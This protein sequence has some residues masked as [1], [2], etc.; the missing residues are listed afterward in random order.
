MPGGGLICCNTGYNLGASG[1]DNITTE[2]R[3]LLDRM[4]YVSWESMPTWQGDPPYKKKMADVTYQPA[5]MHHRT[6]ESL[7][8]LMIILRNCIPGFDINPSLTDKFFLTMDRELERMDIECASPR[9]NNVRRNLLRTL[10]FMHAVQNVFLTG[11]MSKQYAELYDS[12]D[13]AGTVVPAPAF[14]LQH[15]RHCVPW[16]K[17]PWNGTD[18][19]MSRRTTRGVRILIL[20]T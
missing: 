20:T 5:L 18:A 3:A 7:T 13:A 12:V 8:K 16:I 11:A 1:Q 17:S 9:D 2:F 4:A 10:T 15:L 6:R 14:S 19:Y